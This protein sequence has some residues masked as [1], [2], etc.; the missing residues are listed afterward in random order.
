MPHGARGPREEGLKRIQMNV[1]CFHFSYDK[2][3][4]RKSNLGRKG[5]TVHHGGIVKAVLGPQLRQGHR[6][7]DVSMG[8]AQFSLLLHSSKPKPWAKDL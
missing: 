4:R 3:L 5:H 6:E 8:H 1:Q 2:I 7:M